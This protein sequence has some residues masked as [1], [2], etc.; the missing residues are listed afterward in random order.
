[1]KKFI[2]WSLIVTFFVVLTALIA[3]G[4]YITSI[5]TNA[6]TI[7][8][9]EEKLSAQSLTIEVYDSQ[10]KPLKED[11]EINKNY[12]KLSLVPKHCQD[13]FL[14]IE[15]KNFY[16][17]SGVNYKRIAKAFLNNIKSRKLKEGASTI[18]QQ[19][20]K[21]TL[22][23]SEKTLERKIKEIALAKK[24][25]KKY[26][27]DEI[28]EKYLN[29][30]YFGNNCYGIENASKY[31]FS[32]DAKNLSIAQS[33]LLAGIIKSPAKYSPL[34]NSENCLKRRNLVLSEMYKDNKISSEQYALAKNSDLK[35]N[36]STIVK[37]KLNSYSQASIDEAEEI[38]QMPARQI[39]LKG[40][41]LY[42]YQESEKQTALNQALSS[43]NLI[44]DYGGIVIDNEKLGICAYLGKSNYKVLES[45]RQPGSTIK[46]ILVYA[47]ALDK[48]IIYPCTQILDE[49]TVIAQYAP[50]NVGGVYHGYVSA[51]DALAKSINIPAVK[52]L[53]YVGIENAK[54]YA[55]SMGIEFDNM[56]DSYA[57]ALGGMT[58]GVN[59]KQLANAYTTFANGGEYGK[60]R[61][62]SFITD[63]NGKLVYV[64]HPHT[65]KVMR[66]D[67]A[68]L[69]TNMLTNS[70]KN[71]TARK[72]NEFDNVASKTG[73]VGKSG[74]NQ[75][76][77][78]WNVSYTKAQ[79]IGVWIG[80]LDNNPIDYAG[81]NQPTNVV[82]SYFENVK[83]TSQFV[84]PSSIVERAIDSTELNENHRIVLANDFMPD[85]YTQTEIFSAF[86]LPDEVSNKFMQVQ[87]QEFKG[88]TI[89]NN[90]QISFNAKEYITY[91]FLIDGKKVK[92]ISGKIGALDITLPLSKRKEDVTVVYY[93][94]QA[95]EIKQREEI[96]FL[97]TN[98]GQH[99]EKWYI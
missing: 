18:T 16:K 1:M 89:N 13:A 65:K 15:D 72:L 27:K 45:L 17:H 19:L 67:S 69:L 39:A 51:S 47:P 24:L 88:K 57:L 91:D 20:V 34:K 48:D 96:S 77:D 38:L 37:N 95:P 56:D 55:E 90:I 68:Y 14:S 5:Y 44:S 28:L 3:V 40:Y 70:V 7:S 26:T 99:K 30:I 36:I 12:V 81:G 92:S 25:E 86:N 32:V 84:R 78:A 6:Q 62:I 33:A 64:N 35:I 21:N 54:D 76:L 29:I 8:L 59:L 46:P 97:N 71:G 49:K 87:K 58:F 9:N 63:K 2:K 83:D 93:Y 73:T 23:S 75:N 60:A 53:S 42:T 41:K 61:F 22:L 98:F 10:N 52:I 11:N 85:K 80:N 66:E 31:Y 43:Q 82:K 4:L 50:K 74:S 94:S 79:T